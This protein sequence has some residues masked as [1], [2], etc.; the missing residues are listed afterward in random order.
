MKTLLLGMGN[1]ILTDDAVGVLVVRELRRNLEGAPDLTIVEE[2]S[3]GGLN[4]LDVIAGYD[5][6]IVVDSIRTGLA[7][8]G[9]WRRFD[10]AALADTLHLSSVHDVNFATAL[11]LGRQNG[12][13]LPPD[14]EIHIFAI[15]V[16][17]NAT[18]G[19]SLT[20]AVEAALPD[21]TATILTHIRR[22]T[23][24]SR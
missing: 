21:A 22:L 3:A 24:L 16:Q 10:G 2:C 14:D 20:P 4:I 5:R 11:A 13:R 17:D 7:A 12:M 18:F 23:G 15:E 1:P 9:S 19:E 8:P 6:L